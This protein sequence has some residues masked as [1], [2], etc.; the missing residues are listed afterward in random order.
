MASDYARRCFRQTKLERSFGSREFAA[1]TATC[2]MGQELSHTCLAFRR[3]GY[4]HFPS[5]RRALISWSFSDLVF[6]GVDML[7]TMA[8]IPRGNASAWSV[9]EPGCRGPNQERTTI[10]TAG[11]WSPSQ[12]HA[13][14][15][16]CFRRTVLQRC[17]GQPLQGYAQTPLSFGQEFMAAPR[18]VRHAELQWFTSPPCVLSVVLARSSYVARGVTVPHNTIIWFCTHNWRLTT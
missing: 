14:C 9:A 5:Q 1:A 7:D 16:C 13:L 15:Y 8:A 12:G 10:A 11:A 18:A 3:T 2:E 17:Q 6:Y 4:F